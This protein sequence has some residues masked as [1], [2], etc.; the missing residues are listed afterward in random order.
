[1]QQA[2]R[3][4]LFLGQLAGCQIERDGGNPERVIEVMR[5][6]VPAIVL[7]YATDLQQAR[8]MVEGF[9]KSGGP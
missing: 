9:Y 7:E 1:V 3:Y 6:V 2:R 5:R 4:H 8:V